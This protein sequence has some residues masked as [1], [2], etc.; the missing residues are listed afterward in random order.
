MM[1]GTRKRDWSISR[2]RARLL[3][4]IDRA[5]LDGPQAIWRNGKKAVVV[6][7]G[8]DWERLRKA[9]AALG[10]AEPPVRLNRSH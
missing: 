10:V 3:E 8:D 9:A 7:S 2:A 1:T 4:V 5:M 6:L